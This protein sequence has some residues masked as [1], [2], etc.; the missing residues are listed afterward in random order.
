MKKFFL[1][2]LALMLATTTL[3]AFA[4]DA[5]IIPSP[6]AEDMTDMDDT[7]DIA[8]VEGFVLDVQ[9]G[10]ILI[11][12]R[13]GQR[14]EAL[15]TA[16]TLMDGNEPAIGDYIHITCNGQMTKSIPAQIVA[17]YVGDH[18]L[19]GLV[20]DKTEEGFL[21]TYGEQ[22]WQ[23]NA[24]A[25]Q[26][27]LI[28]DGMFI[29][30]FHNGIMTR[31]IPAQVTADHVR[32]M[33]IV[34]TVIEMVEGGFTLTVEGEELPYHVALKEDAMSFVQAE[35]GMTLIV[36]TDGIQSA[37]AESILVNAVE[38][39]PLPAIV[40][41]FDMAGTV[42]EISEE[43]IFITNAQ[44]RPVQ[45][46][47]SEETLY[48]GKTIEVGDYIHVTY[49]GQMTRSIPA[50][51]SALKIGCYTHTGVVSEITAEQFTLTT[52]VEIILVNA[53]ADLLANLTDGLTVTVYSNGAMT[54]S[55]P[56]QIGAELITAS[57]V[58]ID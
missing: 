13:E 41:L 34:G 37:S 48:E 6:G 15:L 11:L 52:D 43:G 27:A 32:G 30:V 14:I 33:E 44:G 45:I 25:D 47:T 46:L 3:A 26:L 22:V 55:L 53:T 28:Q 29:T 1:M 12:T 24:T 50:Q 7:A 38:V 20:S 17:D 10:S 19:M 56:A 5:V 54:M 2:L 8:A 49:D 31:S 21:L 18:V 9:D 35:P 36:V 58:I 42:T 4:E 39:L 57:S 51:I 16:D 23:V 40:E